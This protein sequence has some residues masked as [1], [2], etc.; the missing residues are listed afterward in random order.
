[1]E[2]SLQVQELCILLIEWIQQLYWTC[3]SR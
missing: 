2:K 1:M 3:F